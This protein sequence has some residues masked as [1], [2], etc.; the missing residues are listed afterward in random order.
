[1]DTEKFNTAWL[2]AWSHKDVDRLVSEF[3]A[4]DVVYRDPR[5]TDGVV[6]REA[7]RAYLEDFYGSTPPTSYTP[8]GLWEFEGG[9]VAR[10]ICTID[11]PDGARY[12]RGLELVLLKDSQ[13]T[14][15]DVYVQNLPAGHNP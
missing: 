1:M 6:G 2:E 11:Q 7:L 14:L 12:R 15:E 13:I 5:L 10:W 9:Y 4:P 8:D 3:Y